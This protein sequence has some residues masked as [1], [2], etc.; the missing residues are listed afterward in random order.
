MKSSIFSFIITILAWELA[1]AEDK[2]EKENTNQANNSSRYEAV[3]RI[4]NS[5]LNPK[6]ITD[7]YKNK[8]KKLSKIA[9]KRNQTISQLAIAWVL[10]HQSM[11]SALIGARN[12]NQL[13]ECLV[14]L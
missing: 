8:I 6:M 10:R 12:V 2:N 11:T 7:S 1:T 14:S 3:V 9:K 13:D 5:S 4:E